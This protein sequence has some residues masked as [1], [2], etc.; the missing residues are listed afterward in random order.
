MANEAQIP[1]ATESGQ[2]LRALAPDDVAALLQVSHA[3]QAHRE[4]GALLVFDSL[5]P[6]CGIDP[7]THGMLVAAGMRSLAVLPLRAHGDC[8]GALGFVSSEAGAF[9]A[10]RLRLLEEV[11]S[12]VAIAVDRC[13]G[14]EDLERSQREHAALV[15]MNRA[16]GR[17]LHRDDLFGA[18]AGCLRNIR[19]LSRSARNCH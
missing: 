17:H 9:G 18:L 7:C 4:G 12:A 6:L 2:R 15:E 14:F 10:S 8:L 19:W 3:L 1:L 13:L 16:I 11:S 5:E